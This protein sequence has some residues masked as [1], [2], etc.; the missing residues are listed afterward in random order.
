MKAVLMFICFI[1][2]VIADAAG[3]DGKIHIVHMD[4][5]QMPTVFSSHEHWY[6][7]IVTSLTTNKKQEALLYI[8]DTVTHGFSAKLTQSELDALTKT[9]G[10]LASYPD[11]TG[12]LLTT[13]S[14]N[15]LGL[16]EKSGIW[17]QSHFGNSSD[18]IIGLLDTG[19]WPESQSFRDTGMGEVP[20]R[21]KGQ[22]QAGTAFNSSLC[23]RKL[24][25]ARYFNKGFLASGGHIDRIHDYNSARDFYSHGSHTSSTAAGN[26]VPDVD[27]F[28]YATGTA[29]GMAPRA[30]LAMYK[31]SWYS[32]Y[33]I[34]PIVGSDVL[35]AIE[36]AIADGVDVLSLSFHFSAKDLI[37]NPIA[38]G[39]FA[40]TEKGVLVSC[41]AGNDGPNGSTVANG[42]PWI[43]TVGASTIDRAFA[44]EIN[45]GNGK[46]MEGTSYFVEKKVVSGILVFNESSP[47]CRFRSLDPKSVASK[48]LLCMSNSFED[49]DFQIKEADRTGAAGIIMAYDDHTYSL[50]P[51]G[52]LMP[53]V[54][55]SSGQGRLIADYANTTVALRFVVTRLGF[56]PAPVVASFSSRGPY[57]LTPGIVKPDVIAPGVD[58]LAAVLPYENA[59]FVGS[60]PL[61]AN[62]SLDS[63]T[64]MACPHA[65]AVA[66]LVKAVHPEWSPA[67][68]RS[69]LMTTAYRVDNTGRAITDQADPRF[70]PANPMDFGSGHLNANKA[71]DPG[72]LYDAGV[73]EYL[74]YLCALNYTNQEIRL[75]SRKNYSCA[76]HAGAIGDLNY[77]SFFADFRNKTRSVPQKFK[78]IVTNVAENENKTS[79]VYTAIVKT[80]P[81]ISVQVEPDLLV[82]KEK[83]EKMEFSVSITPVNVK[84]GCSS[85]GYLS[86]VDGR[87]HEVNSPLV[88]IFC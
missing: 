53:A 73:N 82:F 64:S 60:V 81:E 20:A 48:I 11:T 24:I 45:L 27:Y 76:A 63:G 85:S 25:G 68:I 21:W 50:P 78:R 1:S 77:P 70:G 43:L 74:D 52:Y 6:N 42:A 58:I 31:V 12:K 80:P 83:N 71:A 61:K 2:A 39:A 44:A 51:S 87:G 69:A 75:L 55:V 13:H 32:E 88:A 34:H 66:A 3:D 30:R 5:S 26:F 56:K 84:K 79:S 22:C 35:A 47:T 72:L 33:P 62:Y 7:S 37:Q 4:K 14:Y 19:I 15:I 41:S 65:A 86:W 17:P 38:V 40:A 28:G 49:I 36:T 46:F 29:R 57:F 23:N 67:A 9:R 10:H 16:N 54:S 8:Y 59:T 18:V